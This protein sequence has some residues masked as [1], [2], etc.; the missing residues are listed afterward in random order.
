MDKLPSMG[1]PHRVFGLILG[2]VP[3]VGLIVLAVPDHEGLGGLMMLSWPLPVA[4]VSALRQWGVASLASAVMAAVSLA[5]LEWVLHVW[6][7]TGCMYG[8]V[9]LAAIPTLGGS[10]I[11]ASVFGLELAARGRRHQQEPTSRIGRIANWVV[12]VVA[13]AV[14]LPLVLRLYR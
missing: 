7:R 8:F 13:L 2:L 12:L 11:L 9:L 14:V 5:G 3:L 1:T 6:E 10:A 4:Y